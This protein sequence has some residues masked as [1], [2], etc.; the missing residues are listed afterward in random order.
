MSSQI[1]IYSLLS[2]MAVSLMSLAG[3]F[4]LY[5]QGARLNRIL[6]YLISIAAGTLIGDAFIHLLPE[7]VEEHGFTIQISLYVL[8][9]IVMSFILEKIIH[10][11]HCHHLTTADHPHPFAWINLTGDAVHNFVDGLIIGA[12]YLADFQV[13]LVTTFAVILHEI[14]QEIGDYGVLIHGGFS[15]AK[16]LFMNFLTALTAILG[17]IVAL[18]LSS[19]T[20]SLTLFLVPFA[21]GIFIYIACA[22]LIPELH[23]EENAKKSSLQ[24]LAFILGI[25]LMYALI[26]IEA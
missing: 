3:L 7:I 8:G 23:R 22:D 19:F 9:G 18:L 15:R 2:T 17:T 13:G 1:W 10:W 12:A 16:A 6:T 20:E 4:T 5:V 25:A 26:F 24:L 21:A 14:P 11:R